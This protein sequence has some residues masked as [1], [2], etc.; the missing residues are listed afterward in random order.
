MEDRALSASLWESERGE[1]PV[2]AAVD[3]DRGWTGGVPPQT[4]IRVRQFT[5]SQKKQSPARTTH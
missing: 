4:V 5:A 1:Y 2:V 3:T